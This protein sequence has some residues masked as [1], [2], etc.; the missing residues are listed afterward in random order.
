MIIGKTCFECNGSSYRLQG[1]LFVYVTINGTEIYVE[2]PQSEANAVH[3]YGVG[4]CIAMLD[5]ITILDSVVPHDYFVREYESHLSKITYPDNIIRLNWLKSLSPN[6]TD[7]QF[8]DA[9][10]AKTI[11]D[12]YSMGNT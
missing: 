2:C 5:K 9:V 3:G 6:M 8:Q 12:L 7:Q 10:M 11:K 4:G 1:F